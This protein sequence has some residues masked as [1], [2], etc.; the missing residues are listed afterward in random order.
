MSSLQEPAAFR[1]NLFSG[2]PRSTLFHTHGQCSSSHDKLTR[3][4][5]RC[6][7]SISRALYSRLRRFLQQANSA[8]VGGALRF[9]GCRSEY[10]QGVSAV[11]PA[12]LPCPPEE[13]ARRPEPCALILFGATGDLA[14]RKLI[15]A[16]YSLAVQGLLPESYALVAFARRPKND[17][18]YREDLRKAINEFAPKLPTDGPAWESFARNVFYHRSTLDDP[19]G[20]QELKQRLGS[21]DR[22]LGLNGNRLFYL[23]T[24]P[25]NFAEIAEHLGHAGL[26]HKAG[27]TRG[28][29][30][31]MVEK[32]FGNDLE[33]ARA[34]NQR[35]RECFEESEIY[36]VDHY[37]GK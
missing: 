18:E 13:L 1:A 10:N 11:I 23:A 5:K 3:C 35:L 32:P 31:I 7:R 2:D 9:S 4:A 22:D 16:L 12:E 34:L 8:E 21:M 19:S 33:S 37:L 6:I 15:P 29:S 24:P 14:R 26:T 20:Y 17:D 36:R 25:E 30:R 27:G 28:W